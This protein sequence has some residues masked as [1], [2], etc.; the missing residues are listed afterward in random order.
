MPVDPGARGR[1]SV[2]VGNGM[3]QYA[4]PC[5]AG[6]AARAAAGW[7]GALS[8]GGTDE[9]G[10]GGAR[11][12]GEPGPPPPAHRRPSCTQRAHARVQWPSPLRC[13]RAP[14][15]AQ[16]SAL[17]RVGSFHFSPRRPAH[18]RERARRGPAQAGADAGA[19]SAA[20]DVVL[21]YRNR[22]STP[23][24]RRQPSAHAAIAPAIGGASLS[25]FE[26]ANLSQALAAARSTH[27]LSGSPAAHLHPVVDPPV[28]HP[29]TPEPVRQRRECELCEQDGEPRACFAGRTTDGCCNAVRA[30]GRPPIRSC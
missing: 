9:P 1:G 6:R 27:S 19:S 11:G 2:W 7:A 16:R 18:L 24:E 20:G 3:C 29:S 23:A 22:A 25:T 26:A 4:D 14:R 8:S 17:A 21:A 10:P 30:D 13:A 15:A 5:A 12:G 28:V